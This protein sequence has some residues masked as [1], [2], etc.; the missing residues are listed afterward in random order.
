MRS[1]I[2]P[3]LVAVVV[4]ILLSQVASRYAAVRKLIPA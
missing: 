2:K 1:Y 3:V 4:V